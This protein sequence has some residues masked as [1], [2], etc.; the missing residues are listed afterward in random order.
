MLAICSIF[1]SFHVWFVHSKKSRKLEAVFTFWQTKNHD[2]MQCQMSIVSKSENSETSIKQHANDW[3]SK[4]KLLERN[5]TKIVMPV[6][7]SL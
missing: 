6:Y 5:L 1:D 4:R 3:Q 7:L 2:R